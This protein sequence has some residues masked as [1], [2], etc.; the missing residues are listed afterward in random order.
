MLLIFGT[1]SLGKLLALGY[2]K[3]QRFAIPIFRVGELLNQRAF[4]QVEA[5]GSSNHQ[6]AIPCDPHISPLKTIR[7]H[8]EKK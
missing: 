2:F 5:L 4:L 1:D 8:K 6:E 7:S 3:V